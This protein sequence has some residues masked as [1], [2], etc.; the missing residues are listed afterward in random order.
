MFFIDLSD[1]KVP[2]LVGKVGKGVE[3]M[4]ENNDFSE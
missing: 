1:V 3:N 2:F 4:G